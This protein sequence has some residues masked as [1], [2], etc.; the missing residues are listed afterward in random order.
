MF[1]VYILKSQTNGKRYVGQTANL[2]HRITSHNKGD[3]KYTKS[4]MPWVLVYS[5]A[6][7]TRSEAIKRELY[8]KT[9]KGREFL[10]NLG[11]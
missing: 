11:Q 3:S 9:G 7:D 2:A 5:E 4:G 10:D 6:Y 1:Y 8:F